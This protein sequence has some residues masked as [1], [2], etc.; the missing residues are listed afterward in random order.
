MGEEKRV[1]LQAKLHSKVCKGKLQLGQ[2]VMQEL[3]RIRKESV[4]HD[5]TKT[6][7]NEHAGLVQC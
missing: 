5:P 4:R 3:V 2:E 1:D 7:F 6:Y